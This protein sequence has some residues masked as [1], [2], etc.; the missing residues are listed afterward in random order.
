MPAHTVRRPGHRINPLF[1]QRWSPR[2]YTGEEIPDS[3]LFSAFEAARW[4]PSSIN[5]QPWRFLYSKRHSA[6]WDTFLHLLNPNNRLWAEKAS[7]LIVVVSKKTVIGRD[8]Q[9]RESRTHSFDTGAAWQNFALQATEAGWPTHAMG[10]FDR[11]KARLALKIP[12]DFAV[13]VAI[14]IGK[15]AD[16]SVLPPELQEKEI[17]NSRHDLKDLIL[18]GGFQGA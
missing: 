3:V 12:D 16:K 13:E 11:E 10:G 1:V 18:E 5:S 17:P 7:A 9:L 6:S 4:A 2:A 14:A 8:G 15:Q